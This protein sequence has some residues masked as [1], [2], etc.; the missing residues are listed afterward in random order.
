MLLSVGGALPHT[1]RHFQLVERRRLPF[2]W[3]M[4]TLV[5]HRR[6]DDAASPEADFGGLARAHDDSP[7]TEL[8]R[9]SPSGLPR[10]VNAINSHAAS[11]QSAAEAACVA[12]FGARSELVA[13][14]LCAPGMRVVASLADMLAPDKNSVH[15]IASAS[16]ALGA[17][18]GHREIGRAHV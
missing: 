13:R 16:L 15:S 7:D 9:D 14:R 11:P 8:L 5:M 10:L 6:L 18:A 12:A 1:G 2:S 3:G 17:L 4:G